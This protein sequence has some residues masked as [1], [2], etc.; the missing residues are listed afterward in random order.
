MLVGF[1]LLAPFSVNATMEGESVKTRG[2]ICTDGRDIK[3]QINGINGI[4]GRTARSLRRDKLKVMSGRSAQC[5]RE[6]Y[7]IQIAKGV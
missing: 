7:R 4:K 2:T 5:P 6:G 1:H 3:H